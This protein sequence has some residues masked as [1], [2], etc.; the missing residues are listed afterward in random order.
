MT[1]TPATDISTP[2]LFGRYRILERLGESRLATVYRATDERLRRTVLLHL[3]RKD[4]V[5]QEQM[6]QRFMAEANASAQ[7]S[8]AALLE[9]FDSGEINGRPYMITEY[10]VGQ[11]LRSLGALTLEHALLYTR[12]VVGAV[13]ACQNRDLSYPPISSNNVLLID[14]GRVKLVEGWLLPPDEV[15]LDVAHYRAPERT[16][17]HPRGPASAVYALGLLLFELIT[18]KRPIGGSDPWAVSQAHL[19]TH[20]PP[21]SQVRPLFHLP[22]LEQVLVRATARDPGQRF[23]TVAAFGAALDQ[24]WRDLSADTQRFTVASAPARRQQTNTDTAPQPLPAPPPIPNPI[25]AP[26]PSAPVE[27]EPWPLDRATLRRASVRRG[28]MGWIVIL[29]LLFLV[30]FGS[31]IGASFIVDRLFAIQLPRVGLPDLGLDLPSWIPGVNQGEVLVV[32]NATALNVRDQPG[33]SSTVIE[34][35]PN[36]TRVRKLEGPE[37]VEGVPWVRVR[38]ELEG[39][40]IEGWVSQNFLVPLE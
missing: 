25:A 7:R 3:L 34:V 38:A 4:L 16:E 39:R 2:L 40:S 31:Y 13:A 22:A 17:G 32:S 9:V 20:I 14:E 11:P 8:H 12:Q 37:N 30:A 5:G 24:L 23:P 6:Q 10:A 33:L 35:I 28:M 36:G 27:A 18:G 21:L 26:A 19:T 29:L 15:P 1:N